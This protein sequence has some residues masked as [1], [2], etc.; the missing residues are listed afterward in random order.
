MCCVANAFLFSNYPLLRQISRP[1]SMHNGK[2]GGFSNRLQTLA[3]S[4][5]VHSRS[6]TYRQ[7]SPL[8]GN[9][10]KP[11]GKKHTKKNKRTDTTT[12]TMCGRA[13]AGQANPTPKTPNPKPLT[14]N[15]QTRAGPKAQPRVGGEGNNQASARAVLS[16]TNRGI[17]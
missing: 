15:P 4:S 1:P 14:P 16:F 8:R 12:D 6:P 10:V 5:F 17:R 3:L 7:T 2:E 11:D 13:K 9:K